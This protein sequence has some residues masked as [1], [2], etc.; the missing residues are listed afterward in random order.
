L[1]CSSF[2]RET[3][4]RGRESAVADIDWEEER[5]VGRSGFCSACRHGCSVEKMNRNGRVGWARKIVW[6]GG[7]LW[8]LHS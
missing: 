2:S 6:V 7:G 5:L 3:R 1:M 4:R 8:S